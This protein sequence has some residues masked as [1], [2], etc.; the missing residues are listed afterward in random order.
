VRE[1]AAPWRAVV[2]HTALAAVLV[3]TVALP[4]ASA[5]RGA[6]ARVEALNSIGLF[7]GQAILGAFLL[8]WFLLQDHRGAREFFSVPPGRWATRIAR[9]AFIGAAG[10]MATI[11]AMAVLAAVAHATGVEPRHEFTDVVIWL[12]TRPLPLRLLLIAVAAVVEEAFFRAFLQPR[13]GLLVATLCFALAHV[14]YGSPLMSGGV[15][16]IGA[17]LGAA[18]RRHRD[19]VVCAVA[20]GTFD[21]IQLLIILPIVAAHL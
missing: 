10:W 17:I 7:A 11:A 15:F 9:G 3:V 8:V 13:V 19:L 14:S 1:F 6:S 5:W 2:A 18:F 20:H 21:A 12:A 4:V 16:V